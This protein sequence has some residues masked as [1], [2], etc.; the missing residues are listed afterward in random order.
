ML[1]D[2]VCILQDEVKYNTKKCSCDSPAFQSSL[3]GNHQES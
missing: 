1:L 2:A 3:G